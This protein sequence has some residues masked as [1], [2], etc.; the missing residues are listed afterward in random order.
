MSLTVTPAIRSFTYRGLV[1]PDPNRK[2][3][4]EEV[5]AVFATTYPEL[6]TAAITGPEVVGDK[7]LY[8]FS[9]ALGVKG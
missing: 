6:A 9:A 4:P 1:L 2:L 8:T 3:S 5:K 7:L